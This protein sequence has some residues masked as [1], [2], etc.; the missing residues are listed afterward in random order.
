MRSI[1]CHSTYFFFLLPEDM[2]RQDGS[3]S[4]ELEFV[5]R[6]I[7]FDLTDA[8]CAVSVVSAAVSI[9]VYAV[10]IQMHASVTFI[11][12]VALVRR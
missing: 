7:S 3:A 2:L 1:E 8:V 4:L 6:R 9:E 10:I 5:Y 12:F 11:T